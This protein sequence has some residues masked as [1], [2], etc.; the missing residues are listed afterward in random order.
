MLKLTLTVGEVLVL[1][2]NGEVLGTIRKDGHGQFTFDLPTMLKIDRIDLWRRKYPGRK[3]VR[4]PLAAQPQ[5]GPN[6]GKENRT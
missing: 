6:D 1:H 2:V 3:P 5:I 4:T